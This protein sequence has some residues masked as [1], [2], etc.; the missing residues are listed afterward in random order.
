M[1][2]LW[3]SKCYTCISNA[4]EKE[5]INVT[6]PPLNYVLNILTYMYLIHI[7]CSF[8]LSKYTILQIHICKTIN[9]NNKT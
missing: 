6:P 8:Y 7:Y 3:V 5:Q 9:H 2:R 1:C 4:K